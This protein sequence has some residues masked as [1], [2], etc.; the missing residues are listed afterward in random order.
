MHE[1]G[2]LFEPRFFRHRPKFVESLR[3]LPQERISA[4]FAFES[5]GAGIEQLVILYARLTRDR[6]AGRTYFLEEPETNLHP[7]L[8]RALIGDLSHELD[9]RFFI[10]THSNVFL[11]SLPADTKVYHFTQR[12]D[13]SCHARDVSQVSE[14]HDVLDALGDR[15]SS[16]LQTN[17]VIWVEGPSDQLYI[18]HWLETVSAEEKT[19][20]RKGIDF[21]FVFYG[22]SV[23]SH[24]GYEEGA[25]EGEERLISLLRVCRY[26]VVVMDRDNR[27]KPAR[28]RIE[29]QALSDPK[30]RL[31][32]VT[33]G[34][35]IENEVG[36]TA[37]LT[38]AGE[39]LGKSLS[40]LTDRDWPQETRFTD[41]IAVYLKPDDEE[42]R[43]P[44]REKLSKGKVAIAQHVVSQGRVT[45]LS[46]PAF[47]ARLHDFILT[48]R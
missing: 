37:F 20:L 13:G 7:K 31:A 2:P 36:R 14:Q 5:D 23:L 18:R 22:G 41:H 10:T 29:A 16:L 26:A 19:G 15:A 24:H 43:K 25:S 21:E 27:P 42:A 28:S 44:I 30:H 8:L 32:C 35:E 9:T 48:T 45:P 1:T 17:C 4:G 12:D 47:V 40:E 6:G 3:D 39:Y 11:D 46:V 38:A 34:Y 33:D